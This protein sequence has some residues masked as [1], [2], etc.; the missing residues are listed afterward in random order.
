MLPRLAVVTLLLPSLVH[1]TTIIAIR[2]SVAV[3]IGADSKVSSNIAARG[4]S[5]TC[6]IGKISS[7]ELFAQ[8][9]F[10]TFGDDVQGLVGDFRAVTNT[11]LLDS[12]DLRQ[13]MAKYETRMFDAL[14]EFLNSSWA[15]SISPDKKKNDAIL[16]ETVFV[17]FRS[18]VPLLAERGFVYR[19]GSA[20]QDPAL[21]SN[22][23]EDCVSTLR[24]VLAGER[25]LLSRDVVVRAIKRHGIVGAIK[26][27]I[28]MEAN[29]HQDI[30]GGSIVIARLDRFGLH[31]IQAGACKP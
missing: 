3:F 12:A 22:C 7:N 24:Y 6:K 13:G 20:I 19:D 26:K 8:A 18:G 29:A 31:F 1:C 21:T 28:K 23:L 30:T 27:L 4:N 15:S 2:T 16:M 10:D 9:G 25:D 14:R 5:E 11:A 17:G